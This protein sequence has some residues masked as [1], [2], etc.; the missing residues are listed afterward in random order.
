MTL[1]PPNFCAC[2]ETSIIKSRVTLT[3]LQWKWVYWTELPHC[4]SHT[5][6]PASHKNM[7]L[8]F[9]KKRKKKINFFTCA[10][11]FIKS[12]L[13]RDNFFLFLKFICRT[14]DL[15]CPVQDAQVGS[16]SLTRDPT[17]TPCIRGRVWTTGPPGN[18]LSW[19]ILL[20]KNI[21]L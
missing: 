1:C 11:D 18:S 3:V 5:S 7:I 19:D 9:L 15:R 17:P 6:S 13:L 14:R 8:F 10:L 16:S 21:L 20:L 2:L 12:C 4:P